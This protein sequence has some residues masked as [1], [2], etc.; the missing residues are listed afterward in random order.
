MRKVTNPALS[1][2]MGLPFIEPEHPAAKCRGN[3]VPGYWQNRW[4]K[5][6][7]FAHK[8]SFLRELLRSGSYRLQ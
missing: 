8:K 2:L 4:G 7:L 5:R 3:V 6:D 1:S